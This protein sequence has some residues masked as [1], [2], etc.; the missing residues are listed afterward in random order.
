MYRLVHLIS[1]W[2]KPVKTNI[3]LVGIKMDQP[4]R[5]SRGR[6][7]TFD[8][9]EALDRAL[10]V[11]WKKGYQSTSLPDLTRAMAINR[12]SLYAAFGD[13][14]AL[15]CK[16]LQRYSE[17]RAAFLQEA[18]AAPTAREVARRILH[19]AINAHATTGDPPGCM[20]VRG[21]FSC[22]DSP[23]I[24]RRLAS[25]RSA[26]ESLIAQRF[27][28]ALREGDLPAGAS[29]QDLARY[30]MTV[31]HG[32]AVQSSGNASRAQLLRVADTALR[33]FPAC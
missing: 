23:T 21:S 32:L 9:D 16:A 8:V 15:F 33:A 25:H 17:Q 18:L 1:R 2:T 4:A 11:F 24:R 5:A 20:I 22:G 31:L 29:P 30:L 19:G 28:R 6:P 14:Q 26:T 3:V 12:P 10:K 27:T 13:K 7:R